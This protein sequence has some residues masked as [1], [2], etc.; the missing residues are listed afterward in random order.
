M[1]LD[2][3]ELT[4]GWVAPLDEP[5]ARILRD[6]AAGDFIQLRIDLGLL[7]M[8]TDGRPDGATY[9]GFPSA[10]EYARHERRLGAGLKA[11]DWAEL[12]RELH[13]LNYRR[14]AYVYLCE[15]AASGEDPQKIRRYVEQVLRDVDAC[16]SIVRLF[17]ESGSPRA[18]VLAAMLPT[19]SYDRAR[20]RARK[21]ALEGD[22]D[23]AVDEAEAGVASLLEL[24]QEA[25]MP[26]RR[27]Q[28]DPALSSLRRLSAT[29]RKRLG[30]PRTLREQLRDALA[31]ED[32]ELAAQVRDA[33]RRRGSSESLLNSDDQ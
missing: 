5:A 4:D 22:F 25:E 1:G 32:F 11:Q 8:A 10:L 19:L 24:M 2:L 17:A 20:F 21:F 27:Q 9:A 15:E 18:A 7:Q 13:Q 12:E 28:R 23:Q 33:L 16:F 29:L 26:R 3:H 14:I 6:P 30:A 31:A